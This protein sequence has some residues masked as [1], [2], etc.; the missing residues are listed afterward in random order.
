MIEKIDHIAI[1]VRDLEKA[2]RVYSKGLGLHVERIEESSEFHVR[3]AFIPVG[4]VYV[5]LIEPIGPGRAKDFLEK[6]GEGLYHICYRVADIEKA[7]E[8]FGSTLK[9]RDAIP[10][11]GSAGALVAFLEP[12]GLFSVY[13]ELVERRS[14]DPNPL[15]RA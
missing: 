14:Q 4:D 7:M 3:M 13:T 5:E 12:D 8:K 9:F 10:R 6:N 1:L 2:V 15:D 11:K